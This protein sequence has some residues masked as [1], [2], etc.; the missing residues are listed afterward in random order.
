MEQ[1]SGIDT[2][3]LAGE[4]RAVYKSD[5][6]RAG[7]LIEGLLEQRLKDLPPAERL[8]VVDR[9]AGRFGAATAGGTLSLEQKEV[10]RMLS[11]LLGKDIPVENLP[12]GELLEKLS[13]S[14]NTVFD[15]LNQII[16]VINSTLLGQKVELATIRHIIGSGLER[17]GTPES[18]QAY[19]DQ[20]RD[21]FVVAHRAF[22]EAA[23]NTIGRVLNELDPDNISAAGGGGLKFG[24]LRK[25]GS[26]E[27]YREKF[28]AC[29]GWFES[30]RFM[31]DMLREFE[32]ICQKLYK[33]NARGVL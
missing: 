22:Q 5:S 21:A 9:L 13:V 19:L 11:L 28:Q 7:Q 8:A 17:E 15:T 32:K 30:G 1:N 16:G 29:K 10:S 6:S 25:A 20:I 2:D 31:E 12:A 27:V 26:F 24:P 23:R 4:I 18:L 33:S 14:L 3:A